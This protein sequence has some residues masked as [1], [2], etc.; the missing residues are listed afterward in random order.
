MLSAPAEELIDTEE[1][2][3]TCVSYVIDVVELAELVFPAASVNAPLA[4]EIEPFHFE[5]LPLA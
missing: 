3:G 5:Y 2:E 4:T 1:T